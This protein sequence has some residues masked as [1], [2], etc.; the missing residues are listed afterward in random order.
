MKTFSFTVILIVLFLVSC[1]PGARYERQLKNAL[2]SGIRNDSLFMGIYLGMPEKDFYTH[3]WNLNRKGLIKQ[4]TGNTSVE[5]IVK[6]ELLHPA[7]MYFYPGFIGGKVAE[8]P[9][10]FKYQGWAPW[11]KE[12]SS[13]ALQEDVVRYYTTIYGGGFIKVR[14][15]EKGL[16]MVKID[17]NRRISVFKNDEMSV[18]AVFTDMS[19]VKPEIT[20]AAK[21]TGS[22]TTATSK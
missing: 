6:D 15:P 3:C 16:A 1:S 12:L 20:E 8:M 10:Q 22:D 2:A 14:H 18:W 11:N 4:G 19:V 17:G 9:V 21:T 5:H 7:V 13:E